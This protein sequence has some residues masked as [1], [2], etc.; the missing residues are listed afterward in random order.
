[1]VVKVGGMCCVTSTAAQSMTLASWP[2]TAFSA[3]GPPVEEPISNTRGST[4]ENGRSL[5]GGDAG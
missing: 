3:W 4:W 1:M 2:K 5:I